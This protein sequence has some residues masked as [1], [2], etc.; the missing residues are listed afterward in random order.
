M[1]SPEQPTAR[2]TVGDTDILLLGTAHVSRSSVDA[3]R[4]T[5]T[6]G[7]FNAVGVELCKARH[8]AMVEP[9]AWQS[10]DLFQVIR[11]GKTGVVAANLALGA[12]QRRLAEQFGIEPGAE[13]K[14]AIELARERD[15]DLLV[16]DRDVGVTLRRVY[17]SLGFFDRMAILTGLVSS[18]FAREE[19]TE[20]D[21]EQLKQGDLLESTFAEFA[22][23]SERLFHGLISERDEYM[24]ASLREHA[25]QTSDDRVLAV[26]GAGHLKGTAAALREQT[27]PPAEIK[28]ELSTIPPRRRWTRLIP[29][30]ITLVILTGFAWG[31]SRS[32]EMG[33]DVVLTWVLINGTLAALGA[34]IAGGHPLTVLSGFLAAPL[35]SLNPTVAAGMVTASVE[36]Y[37][38]RPRVSDMSALR[39][40]VA[41]PGGWWR[42]RVSRTMLVLIFSNLGSMA[43]TWIAGFQIFRTLT[44]S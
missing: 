34:L 33:L 25:E 31:F 41:T 28:A 18:L 27:R 37:L 19:I 22:S 3:V 14:A 20:E 12:Y 15:L 40:D 11:Q 44:G 29:W 8:V 26:I 36:A 5:I 10:M 4:E 16:I 43:G 9:D 39:D 21:I 42:N 35:T 7:D 13:M 32:P 23:Q 2:V 38:R 1:A 17:R 30:A 24:A 6:Q